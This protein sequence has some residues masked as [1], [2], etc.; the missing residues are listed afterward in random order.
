MHIVNKLLTVVAVNTRA[1]ILCVAGHLC[2]FMTA[3]K[4]IIILLNL[5]VQI[6]QVAGQLLRQGRGGII[7]MAAVIRCAVVVD[8]IH[9]I[10][11][12]F[13]FLRSQA[14]I[15]IRFRTDIRINAM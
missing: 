6:A 8:Y 7:G 10:T 11:H 3:V 9:G 13:G 2:I 5:A 12:I 15:T 1:V 4:C 14:V